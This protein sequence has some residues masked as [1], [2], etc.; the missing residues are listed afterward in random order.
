MGM[1][2]SRPPVR[3]SSSAVIN[4]LVH[5]CTPYVPGSGWGVWTFTVSRPR[6]DRYI[7]A[8]GIGYHRGGSCLDYLKKPI[9]QLPASWQELKTAAASDSMVEVATLMEKQLN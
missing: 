5:D 7:I 4:V 3:A 9:G 8:C 1:P 6:L 2:P